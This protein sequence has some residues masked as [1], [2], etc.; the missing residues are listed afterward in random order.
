MNIIELNHIDLNSIGLNSKVIEGVGKSHG[1][2]VKPYISGHV[3]DGSSTFTFT[4][5][6]NESVT[7][8]VDANGNWKW[9]ADRT[10]T[11]L[12]N[13]F[14]EKTNISE[15]VICGLKDL[16]AMNRIFRGG[17]G[18]DTTLKKV[19]FKK[20]DFTKV[21]TLNSGFNNRRGLESIEGLDSTE[22][23]L[24]TNLQY[25]FLY[26][27]NLIF[28]KYFKW[29]NFV[30]DKV[31]TL[32]LAFGDCR[33]LVNNNPIKGGKVDC[34]NATPT[35]INAAFQNC[36]AEVLGLPNISENC[37]TAN[38]LNGAMFLKDV[39]IQSLKKD[40]NF[41]NSSYLTEQSI[42]NLFN[43]VAADGITLTF[44]QNVWNMIMREID[45][46]DSPIQVAYQNMIDNYDVTIANASFDAEI[47]YLESNG[48][49]YIDTNAIVKSETI[50]DI[51]AQITQLQ[52]TAPSGG[53]NFLIGTMSANNALYTLRCLVYG[54][55]IIIQ[56][57]QFALTGVVSIPKDTNWHTYYSSKTLCK[58]DNTTGVPS[59]TIT[60]SNLKIFL[61]KQNR[62]GFADHDSYCRIAYC[63][64][65]DGSTLVRDFIPVRKDTTGYLYDKVSGNLFGNSGTGDFILGN[66]K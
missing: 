38:A 4:V 9:V 40:L 19:V 24:N 52:E 58:I 34:S 64:I 30:T 3:T 26:N 11:S 50:Y 57:G 62:D 43:A 33:M 49:Q 18:N 51:K 6:G 39:T 23:S 53:E 17:S 42:V 22:W 16:T 7:V 1:G 45:V 46:Q 29:D 60:D 61:F 59:Y 44:H 28:P 15:V 65:Y 35:S 13:A 63:K 10:I 55:N 20:C 37:D 21:T 8:P 36:F 47:E 41:K 12:A 25:V 14:N 54:D 32:N 31:E 27:Y 48:T 5:N 66:D 56:R 2:K